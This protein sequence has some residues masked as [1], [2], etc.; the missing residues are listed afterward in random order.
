[1]FQNIF[2]QGISSSNIVILPFVLFFII[3]KNLNFKEILFLSIIATTSVYWHSMQLIFMLL[4]LGI[5]L[6]FK[7]IKNFRSITYICLLT[8][9]SL[10]I[11]SSSI[12]KPEN[13]NLNYIE[14]IVLISKIM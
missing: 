14:K 10:T 6:S 12:V 4:V 3:K 1:M 11:I 2:W 8:F 9:L 13:K 7:N 5:I